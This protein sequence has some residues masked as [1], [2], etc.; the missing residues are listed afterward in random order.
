MF[1]QLGPVASA[2]LTAL[3]SL[4]LVFA[5]PGCNSQLRSSEPDAKTH[6]TGTSG[7]AQDAAGETL[8]APKTAAGGTTPAL[9]RELTVDLGGGVTLE[10][11]LIPAGEFLMGSPDSDAHASRDEKPPHRARITKPFYL[12]KYLVTQEQWEALMGSNPSRFKGPKNPAVWA[13][14]EHCQAFLEKL[15]TTTGGQGG[16][17]LLPTEAQWEY[18]CR[19]GSTTTYCFGNDE[20]HLGEYAWYK[21]NA[22]DKTHPVGLKKPNAWGLYDMHGNAWEWCQDWYD[23]GQ[24]VIAEA[25]DPAGPSAGS[26]RVRRGNGKGFVAAGCRSA[27]RD[28]AEP[29]LRDDFTGFRVALAPTDNVGHRIV[30][31]PEKPKQ[32]GAAAKN[33]AKELTLDLRGGIQLEMALIPAGEFLMGSREE[34]PGATPQHRVRI[35]KPFYLGRYLVTQEQWQA[36]MGGNPSN[37]KGSMNPVDQVTWN[38][39]QDFLAKL[40]L[41]TGGKAGKFVLPSEAQWEYACRAGST[42]RFCCGD[43]E[44]Q[45]ADC[46][47][48]MNNSENKTHIVGEKKP[49]AW[50]LYDMHGNVWEWCQDWWNEGYY[51]SAPPDDP[52]GPFTGAFR[53]SRGG[54]WYDVPKRCRSASRNPK[55][56]DDRSL[57]LGLRVALIPADK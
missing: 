33:L 49:N 42:T 54:G 30:A 15:N 6:A 46:A 55:G 20:T 16:K 29:G 41:M 39:C 22:E 47:W 14:W 37:F 10:M 36:L 2:A 1:R 31:A 13:S 17:F 7:K 19:A 4:A 9:P 53:V 51:V 23:E 40:N 43:D 3:G 35:T 34:D 38:Q 27:F 57:D 21:A 52:T 28:Y 50:G 45:L 12:G 24:Y 18:A 32:P 26:V 25:D 44:K 11:V 56:P 8:A 5:M 48:Y